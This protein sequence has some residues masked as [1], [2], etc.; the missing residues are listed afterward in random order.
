MK[1]AFLA[2]GTSPGTSPIGRNCLALSLAFEL[3][4]DWHTLPLPLL[5]TITQFQLITFKRDK[6]LIVFTFKRDKPY[7]SSVVYHV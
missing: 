2:S 3:V 5:L 4:T 1:V 7:H 6:D